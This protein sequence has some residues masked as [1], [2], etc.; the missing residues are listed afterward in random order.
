MIYVTTYS[1]HRKRGGWVSTLS[2]FIYHLWY[3]LSLFVDFVKSCSCMVNDFFLL[4]GWIDD[5]FYLSCILF[6]FVKKGQNGSCK[7]FYTKHNLFYTNK[8]IHV[9]HPSCSWS[10]FF[11]KGGCSLVTLMLKHITVGMQITNDSCKKN[12]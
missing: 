2:H 7:M 1:K 12:M 8:V 10:T 4:S 3:V 11:D 6:T 9:L 5:S